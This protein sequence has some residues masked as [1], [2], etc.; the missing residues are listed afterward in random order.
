MNSQ[1]EAS[2]DRIEDGAE[3]IVAGARGGVRGLITSARRG[4]ERAADAVVK[5]KKPL[6]T[7]SGVGLKLSAVSH[8][9]TD[10]VLKQQTALASNQLDLIARRFK[11]A[12]AATGLRDL[13]ADQVRLTPEQF[14]RLGLDAR[15]SLSIIAAGGVEARDVVRDGLSELSPRG[16]RG[17]AKKGGAKKG[18]AKKKAARKS[19]AKSATKPAARRKKASKKAKKVSRK[20]AG[21]KPAVSTAA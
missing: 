3:E 14:R 19:T 2:V 6:A 13:V 8:R 11:A 5:G 15:Q 21:R 12:A 17:G 4:G 18:G 9:T 10:R 7:L 20:T 16:K 1:I